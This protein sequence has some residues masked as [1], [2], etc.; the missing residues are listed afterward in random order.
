MWLPSFLR[1]RVTATPVTQFHRAPFYP[2]GAGDAVYEPAFPV[3]PAMLS[4][5]SITGGGVFSGSSP[6]PYQGPQVYVSQTA[7][8]GGVGGPLAGQFIQQ[9]LNVPETTN[10]SQ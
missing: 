2:V 7:L 10:G 3:V 5:V 8:V 6:N 9:P 4:P 1:P